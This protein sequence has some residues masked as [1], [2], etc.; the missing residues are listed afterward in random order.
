[1]DI[2]DTHLHLWDLDQLNLPWLTN[3][4]SKINKSFSIKDYLSDLGGQSDRVKQAVYIETDVAK[5]DKVKENSLLQKMLEDPNNL[6]MAGI[7]S[8]D[9]LD[10][11]FEGLITKTIK[12]GIVGV[13]HVL[14]TDALPGTCLKPQFLRNMNYLGEHGLL[15]EACMRTTELDDLAV[16]AKACSHTKIVLNHAGNID[17]NLFQSQTEDEKILLDKWKESIQKLASYENIYCKLSGLNPKSPTV[18]TQM[19]DFL[20][21]VFGDTRLVFG[22]NYPVCNLD[23]GIENWIQLVEKAV[24]KQSELTKKRIMADNARKLYH[25]N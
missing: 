6:I 3:D 19:V 17:C 12:K 25:M 20:L 11:D 2:I 18:L 1:M 10:Q 23:L 22:G 8:A 15:F 13:R 7:V 5:T 24:A 14:H 9:L 16:L 21:T 4:Y